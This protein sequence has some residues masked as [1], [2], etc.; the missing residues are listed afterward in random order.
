MRKTLQ[1][2]TDEKCY[3]A[4]KLHLFK[5]DKVFDIWENEHTLY[6]KALIKEKEKALNIAQNFL[7]TYLDGSPPLSEKC[8]S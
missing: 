3:I 1:P 5:I 2:F 7:T 6:L 4:L 8:M